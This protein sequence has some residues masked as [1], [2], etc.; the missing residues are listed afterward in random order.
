MQ[1]LKEYP[2]TESTSKRSP[3]AWVPTLYMAEGIPYVIVMSVALVMYQR[4]GLSNVDI[5]LY[6]S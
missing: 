2:S 4:M 6:T 3:W 1:P 5:T